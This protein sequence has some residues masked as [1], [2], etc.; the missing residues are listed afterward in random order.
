MGGNYIVPLDLGGYTGEMSLSFFRKIRGTDGTGKV[1]GG[2]Y[3]RREKEDVVDAGRP[4]W[5]VP[6]S[7]IRI[8]NGSRS[9][10]ST[11]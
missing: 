4:T 1:A 6:R 8:S 5:N 9:K 11:R 10:R 3:R 2:L 7:I